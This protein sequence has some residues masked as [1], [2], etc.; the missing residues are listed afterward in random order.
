M[1]N[2][3]TT[4][5]RRTVAALRRD[6][7]SGELQAQRQRA[8]VDASELAAEAGVHPVTVRRVETARTRPDARTALA[9]ASA[10]DRLRASK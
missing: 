5:E 3:L 4:D 10:L 9:I 8:G 1:L 7:R 6:A 2:E